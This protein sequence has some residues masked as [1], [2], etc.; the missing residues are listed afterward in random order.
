MEEGP[1]AT[2]DRF[3]KANIEA[4]RECVPVVEKTRA[5]PRSRHPDVIAARD[6]VVKAC[7]SY[8]Q[9]RTRENCEALNEAK[10]LFFNT[11]DKP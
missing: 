3:V 11:Y 2:Y 8:D 9:E 10:Q 1:E 7:Q 6:K 5:P 4:T